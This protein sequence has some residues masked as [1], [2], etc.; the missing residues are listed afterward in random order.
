MNLNRLDLLGLRVCLGLVVFL[1]ELL[2]ALELVVLLDAKQELVEYCLHLVRVYLLRLIA[3]L[4]GQVL[5]VHGQPTPDRHYVIVRFLGWRERLLARRGR[6]VRVMLV[7][8]NCAEKFPRLAGRRRYETCR[9][10]INL[11]VGKALGHCGESQLWT[12]HEL[13]NKRCAACPR[14]TDHGY[15]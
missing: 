15:S 4:C 9:A 2:L 1:H 3:Y 10:E 11:L 6:A 13:S 14:K 8:L 12:V 5:A 7:Q